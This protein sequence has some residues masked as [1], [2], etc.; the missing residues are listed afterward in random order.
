MQVTIVVEVPEIIGALLQQ[1]LDESN[2]VLICPNS[3]APGWIG[4][5]VKET[6]S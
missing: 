3:I 1:A 5:I 2:I 6:P 4:N